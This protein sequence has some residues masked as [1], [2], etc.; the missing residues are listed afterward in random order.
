MTKG[1]RGR[2]SP[3]V[4]GAVLAALVACTGMAAG[5]GCNGQ[6]A[7][8]RVVAPPVVVP[9]QGAGK[10]V[11]RIVPSLG[12][13]WNREYKNAKVRIV[14][15]GTTTPARGEFSARQ[16]DFKE[17][18]GAGTVDIPFAAGVAGNTFIRAVANFCLC[19]ADRC[20]FFSDVAIEVPV[21][22]E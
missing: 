12:Y 20:L 9:A 14:D 22:V 11:I 21:R 19:D 13:H 17:D 7:L 3:A 10:A 18:G 5:A 4:A 8:Y 2:P 16:G 6:K 1:G 15:P